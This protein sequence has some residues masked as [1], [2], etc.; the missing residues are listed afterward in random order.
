MDMWLAGT[1]CHT[2]AILLLSSLSS[3]GVDGGRDDILFATTSTQP[4]GIPIRISPSIHLS[5]AYHHRVLMRTGV[6]G[7]GGCEARQRFVSRVIPCLLLLQ[8]LLVSGQQSGGGLGSATFANCVSLSPSLQMHYTVEGDML[9]MVL[10]GKLRDQTTDSWYLSYGYSPE[11]ARGSEMVGGSA[12]LGGLVNGECFGYEYYLDG[13]LECNYEVGY[14]SCPS[15]VFDDASQS[16]ASL[17]ECE[18]SGDTLAIRMA[19]QLGVDEA[20]IQGTAWP[21]DSSKFA[22]WAMGRV[23]EAS[24]VARPVALL[25]TTETPRSPG[26]KLALGEPQNSCTGSFGIVGRGEQGVPATSDAADAPSRSPSM[27]EEGAIGV[28]N[29]AEATAWACSMTVDGVE[30]RFQTCSVISRTGQNFELMWNLTADPNS[31]DNT[32]MTMGMRASMPNQYVS[33]GFPSKPQSMINAAAMIMANSAADTSL[34]QYYMDGYGVQDVFPSDRGM[35]LLTITEPDGLS[36][37]GEVSGMF[38]MSL[39][40]PFP[41]SADA[42]PL[43]SFPMIFA[44]GDV[45]ADGSLRRHYDDTA[46]NMNLAYAAF[47]NGEFIASNATTVETESVKVAHQVIMA[48]GWGVMIPLGIVGGRAKMQLVAPKWFNVHRYLQSIGYLLGLI[49]VGLG[50]G[51]TKS[52]DTLYPVHRDL[53]ITITVLATVQVTALLWRPKPDTKLRTYWGP[54]H[55]YLGWATAILAIANIYYG[56]LGMGE[57]NVETWAWAVYTAALGC[58]VVLGIFSEYREF[59]LRRAERANVDAESGKVSP[60]TASR[61]A[62]L[63]KGSSLAT[64]LDDVELTD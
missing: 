62:S 51:I 48:V 8:V 60:T 47:A 55:R 39:P 50:F 7:R 19:K 14:G 56:M 38:T 37:N 52:W 32:M 16:S 61:A 27:L 18:K 35:N 44:A 33:V 45:N 4:T 20:G 54:Y 17:V 15:Y 28:I 9:D 10:E 49:G 34:R 23:D 43:A 2:N 64:S 29:A 22:M 21:L 24:T 53:G 42:G 57:Y 31:P 58:I 13:V 30:Q 25:H 26:L 3:Q 11:G 40:Y 46:S 12:L 63:G 6:L 59:V 41:E 36:A 5:L 1:A